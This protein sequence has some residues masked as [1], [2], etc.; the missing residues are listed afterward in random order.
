M[1][2]SS[3]P[4]RPAEGFLKS[5]AVLFLS[6]MLLHVHG[7]VLSEKL[8]LVFQKVSVLIL[9]P[10]LHSLGPL[11]DLH[12]SFSSLVLFVCFSRHRFPCG[13]PA[14]Q[15]ETHSVNQAGLEL[16]DPAASAC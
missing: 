2:C 9:T 16:R 11:K 6:S 15:P 8:K 5:L 1:C 3:I 4:L 10:S 7:S 13:A 12:C 14:G